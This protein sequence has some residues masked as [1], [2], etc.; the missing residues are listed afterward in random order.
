MRKPVISYSYQLQS[1]D[2]SWGDECIVISAPYQPDYQQMSI[3]EYNQFAAYYNK[4]MS[5]YT[6]DFHKLDTLNN[7]WLGHEGDPRGY[8]K[9]TN[10][11]FKTD[12][13]YKIFQDT[14]LSFGH[15][16]ESVSWGQSTGYSVGVTESM[17][18]GFT[19]DG[20]PGYCLISQTL[21]L[22]IACRFMTCLF[23]LFYHKNRYDT[24]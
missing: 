16:S 9:W 5:K 7:E 22:F 19:Y 20:I 4:T 24:T 15:N 14:A 8:I 6:S 23:N 2:G 3:E 17:S 1:K 18:H 21:P 13:R 10:S 12:S 11:K